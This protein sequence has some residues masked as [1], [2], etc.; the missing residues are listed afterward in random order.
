[1]VKTRKPT[2]TDVARL[3]G[4]SQATVSYVLNARPDQ[5]IPA[6]TRDRVQDAARHLN[7]TPNAAARALRAGHSNL[8]LLITSFRSGAAPSELADALTDLAAAAGRSLVIWRRR[9]TADLA[10]T[11][12]HLQPTIAIMLGKLSTD[13]A[14]LFE[15]ARIPVLET[16]TGPDLDPDLAKLATETQIEHLVSRGHRHIGYLTTEDPERLGYTAPRLAGI[17]Q[18]SASLGIEMPLEATLPSYAQLRPEDATAVLQQ[19]TNGSNPVTAIACY[20]DIYAAACI[21]AATSLGIKV[22]QDLAVIGIDD[23]Q[24]ARLTSPA[25]T[26]I[27]LDHS[28]FAQQIWDRALEAGAGRNVTAG[29]RYTCELVRRDS[30]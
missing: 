16:G 18:A 10:M 28:G 8:V 14:A 6:A 1:M 13:E 2:S 20:N 4:V 15:A 3:A 26:T 5:T 17:R 7:Y 24:I 25:L 19:W 11:L 21:A 12:G 22:P 29:I 9:T 23:D 30:T 27:R